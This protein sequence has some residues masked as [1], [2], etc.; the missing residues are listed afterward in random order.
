MSQ[1]T[2]FLMS[3]SSNEAEIAKMSHQQPGKENFELVSDML[4]RK[5][6]RLK[7]KGLSSLLVPLFP[8]IQR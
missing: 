8:V 6:S 4:R 1:G 2:I 3:C 5:T 7:H